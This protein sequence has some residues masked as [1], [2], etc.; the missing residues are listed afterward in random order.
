MSRDFEA[1]LAAFRARP[2]G[3]KWSGFCPIHKHGA[4]R[5]PSV[6]IAVQNGRLLVH[7][8]VCG[9]EATP[10][11][12]EALGFRMTDLF[13]DPPAGRK[14][15]AREPSAT[16]VYTDEAGSPLYRA[17]RF[18][19][20]DG[21][22]YFIQERFSPTDGQWH[23]G[24]GSEP[25]TPGIAFHT[26]RVLYRLRD[27]ITHPE[28]GVLIAEGEAKADLLASWGLV[29][30]CNVG[31]AGMGWLDCYSESLRG[32]RVA[33]LPDNDP[34]GFRH[35]ERVVGSLV[36]FGVQ[37]LRIVQLPGLG[38]AEDVIDFAK[39]GGTR[40]QLVA[41]VKETVAWGPLS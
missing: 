27:V 37:N 20:P 35:A 38:P 32:R 41:L 33:V 5:T 23:P 29:A 40:E 10:A 16:F 18:N 39:R 12:V 7:C 21:K 6:S 25:G 28:Q 17:L 36:R 13:D 30:V 26:R 24:L 11:I 15:V 2:H 9:K 31:G 19:Y 14:A 3:D 4:E 8:F 34:P 22:K 1:I